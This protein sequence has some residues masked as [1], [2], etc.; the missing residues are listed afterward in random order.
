[1]F[2]DKDWRLNMARKSCY[3]FL[4][5]YCNANKNVRAYDNRLRWNWRD[6]ERDEVMFQLMLYDMVMAGLKANLPPKLKPFMI[7]SGMFNS[8]DV[9]LG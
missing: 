7:A 1:M 3:D 5:G 8:I 6:A 2:G 9:L 4:Q